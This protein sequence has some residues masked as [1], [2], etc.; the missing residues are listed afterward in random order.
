MLSENVCTTFEVRRL[1]CVTIALMMV[2]K[3]V[4]A[5]VEAMAAL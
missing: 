2:E 4:E 3:S 5:G 1:L